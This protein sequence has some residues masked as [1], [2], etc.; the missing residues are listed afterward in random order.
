M[1]NQTQEIA[2]VCWQLQKRVPPSNKWQD[3][4]ASE[5]SPD[6]GVCLDKRKRHTMY[7]MHKAKPEPGHAPHIFENQTQE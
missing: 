6:G 1:E 2:V 7:R 5:L 4:D 3:C